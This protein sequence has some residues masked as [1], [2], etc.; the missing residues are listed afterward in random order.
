VDWDLWWFFMGHLHNVQQPEL[1]CLQFPKLATGHLLSL[2]VCWF[3]W[4]IIHP[5]DMQDRQGWGE[6]RDTA[7]TCPSNTIIT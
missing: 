3:S 7:H 5:T 4:T 1:F 6:E 2:R